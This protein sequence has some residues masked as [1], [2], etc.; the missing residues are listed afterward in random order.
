MTG[1]SSPEAGQISPGFSQLQWAREK[2]LPHS[3]KEN[4]LDV[5]YEYAD[6]CWSQSI[7]SERAY[8]GN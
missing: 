1:K 4:W 5:L 8:Y 2:T 3:E 7:T 6:Y